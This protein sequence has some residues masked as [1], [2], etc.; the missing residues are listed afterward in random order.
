MTG[1]LL[2]RH[3]I[4]RLGWAGLSFGLPQVLR[5]LNNII[6]ARLLSPALFG[7]M[8]IILTIRLGVELLS[9]MGF[10]QSIVSNP[11]GA[12]PDFYNTVWTIK[13]IR[14]VLLGTI[15]ALLT[16]TL[17]RFFDKPE[18]AP[19]LPVIALTFVISGFE[20]TSKGLLQKDRRV[21]SYAALEISVATF[22][23]IA[24]VALALMT[25]TIW[26]LVLGSVLTSASLLV[27]SYLVIPG[28]R[29]SFVLRRESVR[30]VVRFGKWIFL[31]S[32]IYFLSLNFDR[33]YFAPQISL[34]ELG[35]YGIARSLADMLSL[36]A[37]H[38]GNL[39]LFPA[40]AAARGDGGDLGARLRSPRRFLMFLVAIGVGA[41]IALSDAA[42]AVLYDDRYLGAA[43]ILALLLI[44]AWF[45]TLSTV[46]E[47]VL[48]GVARPALPAVSQ[49]LKLLTYVIAVPLA[50]QDHGFL[51]AVAVLSA[52]E[53]V[54]YLALW[55][56][57]LKHGLAFGRD[58]IMLTLAV[59]VALIATRELAA[60][61]GLTG[62]LRSL[63]GSVGVSW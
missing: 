5:L 47:N 48:L 63:L 7:V 62:D 54:R 12:E 18:L 43:P 4:V 27:V 45:A 26:A 31:S 41:A 59:I 56:L 11:R 17:T 57:S 58:D 16:G 49:G 52:G 42:I 24:H 19:I 28:L 34:A 21:R 29:H 50:F 2:A 15:A 20:S 61:I 23:L 40:I 44:G 51:L 33:L 35:L 8:Q 32:V 36:L 10:N 6:L 9:D 22:S 60:T 1:N 55:A 37:N 46:Y 25:P 39:L 38:A 3:Q 13:V 14:G 30:E 53:A